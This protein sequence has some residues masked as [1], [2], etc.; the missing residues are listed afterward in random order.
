MFGFPICPKTWLGLALWKTIVHL[1]F[2]SSVFAFSKKKGKFQEPNQVLFLWLMVVTCEFMSCGDEAKLSKLALFQIYT[3]YVRS[4]YWGFARKFTFILEILSYWYG[5]MCNSSTPY[6]LGRNQMTPLFPYWYS[7][8]FKCHQYLKPT[9][10]FLC[11]CSNLI[12]TKVKVICA[13]H[14]CWTVEELLV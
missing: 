8:N 14:N 3:S 6:S 1:H 4:T 2:T 13:W 10:R 5:F 9:S 7:I 12:T 11:H